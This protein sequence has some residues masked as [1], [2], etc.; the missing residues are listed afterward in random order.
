LTVRTGGATVRRMDMETTAW[1]SMYHAMHAQ[2]DKRPFSRRTLR[3]IGEFARP[4]RA[5]L[6]RF[7]LATVVTSALAVATPVLAG[8]VVD[9]VVD[10][11]DPSV[12]YALAALIAV[13]AVAEAGL[14]LLTR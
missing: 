7:L 11:S 6:A 12:V 2:Q 9:A 10:G 13:I 1:M 14:G 8:R 3:R 4:H 5:R